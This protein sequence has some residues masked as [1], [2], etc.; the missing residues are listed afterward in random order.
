MKP[1]T[2]CRVDFLGTYPGGRQEIHEVKGYLNDKDP[3]T[4]LCRC[5]WEMIEANNPCLT[6]QA[7]S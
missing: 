4:R 5:N 1:K 6:V 7:V 2:Y 3:A